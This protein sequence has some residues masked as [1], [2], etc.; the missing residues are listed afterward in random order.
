MAPS[1]LSRLFRKHEPTQHVRRTEPLTIGI[2]ESTCQV[3]GDPFDKEK[4]PLPSPIKRRLKTGK[5]P[6]SSQEQS[7]FFRLP[8]EIRELIYRELFGGRRIHID[9]VFKG[10][11]VFRPQP[12]GKY[13]KSHW[14]WWHLVCQ[15]SSSFTKDRDTDHCSNYNNERMDAERLGWEA[16]PPG[17][18]LAGVEW[19]QCCQVGYKEALPILYGSNVF[20]M[21]P[22]LDSPYQMSRL[23]RPDYASLITSMDILIEMGKSTTEP[24]QLNGAWT[25]VY[26]AFFDLFQS[27][28]CN[29]RQ[30]RLTMHLKPW[31]IPPVTM[32]DEN[33]NTFLAPLNSL[34]KS[35]EW[36]RLELSLQEDWYDLLKDRAG[37]QNGW[38]LSKTDWVLFKTFFCAMGNTPTD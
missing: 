11:S 20:V 21:G 18:K 34:A 14:Q 7:A 23:L 38:T 28:F 27:C 24:P 2:S 30:L 10:P 6:R 33:L 35:R 9:H 22:A 25:T 36:N 1:I 12:Q 8:L 31:R 13:R 4:L 5:R 17:T 16:A 15:E 3:N 29:V 26:P 37:T 19:L 32:N